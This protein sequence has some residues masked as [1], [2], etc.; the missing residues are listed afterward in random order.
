MLGPAHVG[1]LHDVS[2]GCSDG[3]TRDAS[4]FNAIADGEERVE[5]L[6]EPWVAVEQLR[7]ALDDARRV[8]PTKREQRTT[9]REIY[10]SRTRNS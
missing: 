3:D 2:S 5:A 1:G 6:D 10:T 8:D 7:D 4:A 9:K